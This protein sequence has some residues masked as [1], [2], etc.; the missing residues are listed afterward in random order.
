MKAQ[1]ELNNAYQKE[2]MEYIQGHINKIR[3]SVED[4]QFCIVWQ[5]VNEVSKRKSTSQEEQI[6]TWKEHFKNLLGKFPKITD[7]PITKVNNQLEI[8]LEQFTQGEL[9]VVLRK[10]KNMKAAGLYEIAP[11]LWKT[12]KFDNLLL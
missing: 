5:T 12:R 9:H 3:N 8:K 6:H 4:R 1:N 11:E 7:K 2:R 10:I